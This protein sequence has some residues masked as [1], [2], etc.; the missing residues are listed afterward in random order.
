VPRSTPVTDAQIRARPREI[1]QA[2]GRHR[3]DY[4]VIGGVAVQA[5]G[6]QRVTRDIDIIPAP[7]EDNAGRLARALKDLDARLRGIDADLL[8]IDVTDPITLAEGANFTLSTRAGNLDIMPDADGAPPYQQL[9]ARAVVVELDGYAV[10]VA[11]LDDL[12]ALKRSTG[13][14]IDL[15][16]IAVLT[17]PAQRAPEQ[18]TPRELDIAEPVELAEQLVGPRPDDRA[19]RRTWDRAATTVWLYRENYGRSPD[20]EQPLGPRPPAGPQRRAWERVVERIADARQRLHRHDLPT[21]GDLGHDLARL[22]AGRD[23]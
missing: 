22:D 18:P 15:D 2:L 8:G 11:G 19:G 7:G 5:Y 21:P 16:D 12:I 10:P 14:P 23:G 6:H 1:F 3:V 20:P 17:D 13:R 9:R 4:V